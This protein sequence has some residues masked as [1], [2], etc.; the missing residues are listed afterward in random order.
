MSLQWGNPPVFTSSG[1]APVVDGDLCNGCGTCADERCPVGA[2]KVV[3]DKAS[4]DLERCIGCGLCVSGCPN[5]AL[6]LE[7][8]SGF[9]EPPATTS[10]MGL[11][12]LQEKGK[13]ESF[14]EV[15][16]P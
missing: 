2:I 4:V 10:E 14:L 6:R 12:I 8:V 9:A 1:F 16:K 7:P 5:E 15:L 13:L 3:E 11:R